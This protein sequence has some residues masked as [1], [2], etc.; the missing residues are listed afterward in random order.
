MRTYGRV[1]HPV[2]VGDVWSILGSGFGRAS[3]IIDAIDR[4]G[5]EPVAKVTYRSSGRKAEVSL[6]VLEKR[7]R[8][9]RLETGAA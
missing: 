8:G 5:R 9:A 2:S 4:S 3:F 1:V 6:R 7:L